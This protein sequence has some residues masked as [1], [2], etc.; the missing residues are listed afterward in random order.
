MLCSLCP[1]S[2]GFHVIPSNK[3]SNTLS[4]YTLYSAL[5]TP[6]VQ[7]LKVFN[8]QNNTNNTLPN[9]YVLQPCV[10]KY[11]S[12]QNDFVNITVQVFCPN[13]S[14]RDVWKGLGDVELH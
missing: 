10:S 3:I 12:F 13:D 11:L 14:L 5:M 9:V 8:K 6:W 1:S 4:L 2:L 7:I